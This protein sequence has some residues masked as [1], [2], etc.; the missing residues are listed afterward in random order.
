MRPASVA[1]LFFVLFSGVAA[2][3]TQTTV[4]PIRAPAQPFP[5]EEATAGITRFSFVAYGDTRCDCGSGGGPE[6]QI[7][8]ERVVDLAIAKASAIA[9]TQYPVRFV[10]QTGDAVYRGMNAERWDV[11]IPIIE[12]LTRAGSGI[13]SPW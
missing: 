11:F 12:K 4:R 2:A 9:A 8:H 1:R 5:T 7:E 6:V 3:Q 10:I 13:S